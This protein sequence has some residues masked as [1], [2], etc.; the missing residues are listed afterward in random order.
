MLNR[1]LDFYCLL[2][3]V[4]WSMLLFFYFG[5]YANGMRRGEKF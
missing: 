4:S 3:A 2:M 1:T 5:K